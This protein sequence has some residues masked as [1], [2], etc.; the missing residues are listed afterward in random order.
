MRIFGQPLVQGFGVGAL[1]AVAPGA[2]SP[3]LANLITS[4]DPANLIAYWP[5]G[6]LTG[7][8]ADD[9]VGG[10][11]GAYAGTVTL[12]QP[13]IGDGSP[14]VLF[15]DDARVTLAAVIAALDTPFDPTLGTIAIACKVLNAAVW[16]DGVSR[17]PMT[18]G[19]DAN[20]RV[21][22]NK[23]TTNNTFAFN[24]VAGGTFE[25]RNH[26]FSS[27]SW[28][29]AV[30]TWSTAADRVRMYINRTLL[31]TS[32][33]LGTWVGAIVTG[34]SA[35]GGQTPTDTATNWSGWLAHACLWKS[36]LTLEQIQRIAPAVYFPD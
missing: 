21:R 31:Q 18:F 19:A 5:L 26:A 29:L 6:D 36:E 9:P 13:G 17:W 12:A 27:T 4:T 16:T 35:I 10:F 15:G 25:T 2:T 34:V 23:P 20:N 33:T 30:M 24:Y 22:L 1:G 8:V 28:F 7:T 14:S 32:T 11:D 3:T